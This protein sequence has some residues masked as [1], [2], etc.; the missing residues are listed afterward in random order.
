MVEIK[1]NGEYITSSRGVQKIVQIILG[2]VICSVLC[3]NWYGG[4]SCFGDGRLGYISGLNFVIVVMNIILFLLNMMNIGT[5]RFERVY[6]LIV[7]ILFIIAA[8][9]MLWHIIDTGFWSF[10]YIATLVALVIIFFTLMWDY[11]L[12]SDEHRDHLP[13]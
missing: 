6:S 12:L 3:A 1:F 7:S 5:R 11:R 8:G 2:F 13:I 4:T 9:L 10:W